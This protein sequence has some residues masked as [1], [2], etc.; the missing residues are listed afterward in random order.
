MDYDEEKAQELELLQSMYP[1]ELEITTPNEA[2]TLTLP[3]AQPPSTRT[4]TVPH[5]DKLQS[6]VVHVKYTPTYPETPAEVVLEIVTTAAGEDDEEDE[7]AEEAKKREESERQ[8]G[9]AAVYLD[10][11]AL[12][13]LTAQAEQEAED[14][15]GFPAIFAIT[16][17]LKEHCDS[18]LQS[19]LSALEQAYTDKLLA[20]EE[21]EQ[22]KFRGTLVNRDNFYEWRKRF[23]AEMAAAAATA[24]AGAKIDTEE[25]ERR[26]R[27]SGRE[28]FEKGLEGSKKDDDAAGDPPAPTPVPAVAVA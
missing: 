16:S 23:R 5:A 3:L 27:P 13:F 20:E 7:S 28:I 24:A 6:L 14:N 11:S 4:G 17:S 19:K 22:A 26:K 15:L 2:Y 18:L 25:E 1:D 12:D 10:E 8:H 9:F 21:R